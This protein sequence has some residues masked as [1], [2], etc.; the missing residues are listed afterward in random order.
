[1]GVLKSLEIIVI[2]IPDIEMRENMSEA[3]FREQTIENFQ[4]LIKETNSSIQKG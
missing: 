3:K 1:M 4:D 2:G